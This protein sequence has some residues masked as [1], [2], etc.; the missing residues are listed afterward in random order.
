MINYSS[1]II[2]FIIILNF[3]L[4]DELALYK[5]KFVSFVITNTTIVNKLIKLIKL[6]DYLIYTF[7]RI[8]NY[9][10]IKETV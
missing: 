5:M 2:E 10:T 6:E 1:K 9:M 4:S 8:N 3:L 7:K